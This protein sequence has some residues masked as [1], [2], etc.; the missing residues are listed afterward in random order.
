TVATGSGNMVTFSV[1][2]GGT[3]PGGR[4]VTA[5]AT[6]LVDDD[7]NPATP[8]VPRDTSEFS[9]TVAVLGSITGQ[10]FHDL[11]GDGVQELGEPALAQWTVYIDVNGNGQFDPGPDKTH[12]LEPYA[13]TDVNGNYLI[14]GVRPGTDVVRVYLPAGWAATLPAG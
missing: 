5:T 6:T 10:V 9:H 3:V 8:L 7:N 11:N 14:A 13:L 12:P 1:P 4:Y 2:L